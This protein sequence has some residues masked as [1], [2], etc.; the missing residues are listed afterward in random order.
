[1]IAQTDTFDKIWIRPVQPPTQAAR[2]RVRRLWVGY[3]AWR[4]KSED[5]AEDML[6]PGSNFPPL[7]QAIQGFHAIFK[8]GHSY[9]EEGKGWAFVTAMR[10]VGVLCAYLKSIGAGIPSQS[11]RVQIGNAIREWAVVDKLLSTRKR[12]KRYV[13]RED[14]ALF[15]GAALKPPTP[16]RTNWLRLNTIAL[17]TLLYATGQRPGCIVLSRG[18]ENTN[19]CLLY[20]HIEVWITGWKEGEGLEIT[21]FISFVYMKFMRQDDSA[22]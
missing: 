9:V 8:T 6:R 3:W 17:A 13:R 2:D 21:L 19:E 14:L 7:A 4:L 11:D 18:Y 22:Q 16:L 12:E 15:C 5:A 1:M 10:F 20:K